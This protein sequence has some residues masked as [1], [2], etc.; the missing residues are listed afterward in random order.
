MICDVRAPEIVM[1]KVRSE[2][3]PFFL[4][5]LV[6]AIIYSGVVLFHQRSSAAAGTE[7]GLLGAISVAGIIVVFLWVPFVVKR[8]E[9]IGRSGWWAL[10]VLVLNPVV[11][12]GVWF[13]AAASGTP[14]MSEYGRLTL[15]IASILVLVRQQQPHKHQD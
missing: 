14:V 10:L 4:S 15:D 3:L 12:P 2:R 13:G 9:Y 5:Y 11:V 1:P 8:L 7:L 6:A